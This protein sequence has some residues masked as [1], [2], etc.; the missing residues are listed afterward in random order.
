MN[1]RLQAVYHRTL[2]IEKR[3]KVIFNYRKLAKSSF[4]ATLAITIPEMYPTSYRSIQ[5][6]PHRVL[7]SMSNSIKKIFEK[8]RHFRKCKLL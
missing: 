1:E 7:F 8:N 5:K 6:S 2:Q 4:F 3:I